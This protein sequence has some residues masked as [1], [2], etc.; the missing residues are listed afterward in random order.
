MWDKAWMQD[1]PS[2]AAQSGL[3]FG[4][5]SFDQA[6]PS[7]APIVPI[8]PITR[9]PSPSMFNFQDAN[10]QQ[11]VQQ[12]SRPKSALY[13]KPVPRTC[14]NH[15][16][17]D[18]C[19]VLEDIAGTAQPTL[20]TCLLRHGLEEVNCDQR[21]LEPLRECS[22]MRCLCL[23]T[24]HGFIG[25]ESM[26]VCRFPSCQERRFGA[27]EGYAR[28]DVAKHEKKHFGKAGD[29][30]C[31]Q[32]GCKVITKK[33]SDLRRHC[34]SGHCTN[35]T[36]FPCPIIGCKRGGDNGFIRKDRME[37]H[38]RDTDHGERATGKA[39][40]PIKPKANGAKVIK[41]KRQGF[42]TIKPKPSAGA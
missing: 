27:S 22:C 39:F 9:W 5:L 28:H 41:G 3:G 38:R 34:L 21:Y 25:D 16:V 11:D 8:H 4:P 23:G 36:R 1:G 14:V 29:Y 35:V 6:W 7:N 19:A 31:F 26:L 24:K 2:R 37:S 40:R 30:H 32:E 13:V 20:D 12:F 17:R 15:N 33:F 10:G 42:Q 18:K